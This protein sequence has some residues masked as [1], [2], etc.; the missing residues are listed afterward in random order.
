MGRWLS[1]QQLRLLRGGFLIGAALS[2]VHVLV[3]AVML[4]TIYDVTIGVWR[5]R[6]EVKRGG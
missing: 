1:T 3:G 4:W 6:Q 5:E 2:N